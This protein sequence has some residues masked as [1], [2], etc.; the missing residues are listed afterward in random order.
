MASNEQSPVTATVAKLKAASKTPL[1]RTTHRPIVED[2]DAPRGSKYGGTP[3]LAKGESW[4]ACPS[5]KSAL[6]LCLQ[7]DLDRLPAT[8]KS[9][10]GRGVLQVF[11]CWNS[12]PLCEVVTEA[13]FAQSGVAKPKSK[14]ARVLRADAELVTPAALPDL[15]R[16]I[17]PKRIVG[18]EPVE[19]M[20]SSAE[21]EGDLDALAAEAGLSSD[22]YYEGANCHADKLG[23]WPAWIQ[24]V[25]YSDCPICHEAMDNFVFQ[26][27][28]DGV[29]DCSF[30]G[31]GVAY[32]VQC[33]EHK[34]QIDV[35]GQR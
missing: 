24:A 17:A 25:E 15:P 9:R 7:L 31:D 12:D 34:D 8:T 28:S 14:L 2:G 30:C 11:Y 3:L 18:W 1:T 32:V 16:A 19:E 26:L 33:P 6:A 10:W 13:Y 20:P 27:V 29:T 5:C 4:P 22:A 23:G 21:L 35:I